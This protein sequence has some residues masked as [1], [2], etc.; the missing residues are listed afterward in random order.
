MDG[1]VADVPVKVG[2]LLSRSQAANLK[3]TLNMDMSYATI[4]VF[5]EQ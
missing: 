5:A 4:L 1:V 3:G 2:M